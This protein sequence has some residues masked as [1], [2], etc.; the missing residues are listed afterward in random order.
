MPDHALKIVPYKLITD[1]VDQFFLGQH[2]HELVSLPSTQNHLRIRHILG[3]LA[4]H[5]VDDD[6]SYEAV[7]KDYALNQRAELGV[8]ALRQNGQFIGS[9]T[10]DPHAELKRQKFPHRPLLDKYFGG[11]LTVKIYV[12]GPQVTAWVAPEMVNDGHHALM[13]TYQLLSDPL[14]PAAAYFETYAS[15]HPGTEPLAWAL[16]PVIEPGKLLIP[17]ALTEAGFAQE[18]DSAFYDDGQARRVRPPKSIL[19]LGRQR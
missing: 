5:S 9:A 3:V 14:G 19:Y 15:L 7:K 13:E 11:L 12:P 10:V 17:E 6:S 4:L 16:E 8:F 18:G 1:S 2:L